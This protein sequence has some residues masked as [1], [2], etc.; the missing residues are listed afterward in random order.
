M[1]RNIIAALDVGTST[2]TTVVAERQKDGGALQILGIGVAASSGVRRGAIVDMDDAT[3]AI[4]RSVAEAS[5]AANVPVTSVFLAVGGSHVSVSSSRGVVAVSRADQE[6]A[7][8]DVRRALAAAES[9]IPKNPNKEVLHLIPRDFKVDQEAGIKDPIGM[10][11]VRLEADTLIIECST[12]MLKNLLKCVA[13]AGLKVQD[14]VFAP[15]AAAE[16]VLTKRQKEMG[17]MLVDVGGGTASFVVFEEGVPLHA[18]VLPLGGG[19]ITADVAIGFRTHPDIAE[20]I[21]VTHGIAVADDIGKRD[22]IRL[23]DF[24]PDD[25]AVF[26]KR[27]L[28]GIIEARL[29]D[30]FELLQ[31]ELKKINRTRLLPAGVVLIGGSSLIPGVVPLTRREIGLPAEQGIAQG[32]MPEADGAGDPSL[33]V[34]LGV[35]RW[36]SNKSEG[37][38]AGWKSHVVSM[39]KSPILR[40]L[41]SL[42]P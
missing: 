21:K 15:I 41:K 3:D 19:H 9:F 35:A 8:E 2:V 17:V 34:A 27:E 12:P 24:V 13:S 22:T 4:R 30:L 31:K 14:Y 11:G 23:A 26:S 10:H 5:R 25:P 16:A 1:A 39:S 18:G 38:S 7:P 37:G 33:A 28:A 36:A 29:Q 20:E 6:I 42:L 40:W 32:F